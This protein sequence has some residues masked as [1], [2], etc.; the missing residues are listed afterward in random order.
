MPRLSAFIATFAVAAVLCASPSSAQI[1]RHPTGV[2]VN[3]TGATTVFLTFGNL[4]GY[5]PVEALWC[6]ELI[7]ASP[8]LGNR[9]DP[10]T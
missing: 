1:Q 9:C 10:G 6:G 8:D 2:N 3:A 5:V 4:E 7:P